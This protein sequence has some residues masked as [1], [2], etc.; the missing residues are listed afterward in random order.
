MNTL[1]IIGIMAALLTTFAGLPQAVKI[2]RKK[3]SKG[4]SLVTYL[5]LLSGTLLWVAYGIL[6]ADWPIIISNAVSSLISTIILI[7]YM[8][9]DRK[10]AKVHEAILPESDNNEKL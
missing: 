10:I 4:I 8:M 1:D 7:L 9:P 5:V 2:I 6:K 3:T